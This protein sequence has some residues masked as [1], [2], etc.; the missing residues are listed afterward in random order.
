MALRL[1]RTATMAFHLMQCGCEA[2]EDPNFM[3]VCPMHL[4]A[5]KLLEGCQLALLKPNEEVT[6]E[7]LASV[8]RRATGSD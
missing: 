7:F 4:N 3:Q 2:D 1:M 5:T 6:R 8:I